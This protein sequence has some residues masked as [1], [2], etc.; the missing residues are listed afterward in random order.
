MPLTETIN[1]IARL[2]SFDVVR[3]VTE[4]LN[5]N[6]DLIIGLI[7]GQLGRKGTTGLGEPTKAKYGAFYQYVTER[8]KKQEFG[9]SGITDFV[10]L[11]DSGSFY[12]SL[13][14]KVQGTT[15]NVL[16]NVPYFDQIN[17]WNDGQLLNL[18]KENLEFLSNEIVKPQLAERFQN[19]IN[20]V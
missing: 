5:E 4:I 2:Q 17:A 18:D 19:Y 3:A 6:S 16:S 8:H 10:T 9:L 13:D 11:Y 7:R 12:A 15:F 1:K 20:G 14:L